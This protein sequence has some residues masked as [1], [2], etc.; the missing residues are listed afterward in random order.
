MARRTKPSSVAWEALDY[1]SLHKLLPKSPEDFVARRAQIL[2][3]HLFP[4]VPLDTEGLPKPGPDFM[5]YADDL[6]GPAEVE[7]VEG[8]RGPAKTEVVESNKAAMMAYEALRQPILEYAYVK[9]LYDRDWEG[10]PIAVKGRRVLAEFV[11]GT[12]WGVR[13]QDDDDEP[14][15]YGPVHWRDEAVPKP[16]VMVVGKFPGLAEVGAKD[17]FIGVTSGEFVK[18]LRTCGLDPARDP[19]HWYFTNLV[20]HMSVDPARESLAG[21][22]VKNCLPLL[23]IELR[24]FRPKYVLCFGSEAAKHVVGPAAT[25]R[26]MFGRVAERVIAVNRTSEPRKTFSFSSMVSVHPAYVARKPEAASD[27]A[28]AVGGFWALASGQRTA[29]SET[30]IQHCC[31]YT[32]THLKQVV[33]QIIAEAKPGVAQPIAIDCE[34]H[35]DRPQEPG[36]YLRTIQF[37][38]KSKHAWCVVLNSQGGVP[39][40]K[41]LVGVR[42]ELSR[43][44]K[45]TPGKGQR[46]VR[47]GGHFLRADLPWL[48]AMGLDLRNEYRVAKT[49]EGTRTRGGFDTGY[50]VH[51]FQE[52]IEG[53][54]KLENLASRFCGVPRYDVELQAWKDDYCKQRQLKDAE[55]EGYGQAPD[56]I[57]HRYAL[58]DVDVTFRLFEHFNGTA[59]KQGLLDKPMIRLDD[60]P[61]PTSRE[62]FYASH[63]AALGALEM[64]LAGV[65][66]D[67]VRGNALTQTFIKALEERTTDFRKLI[68]WDLFNP[69]S[70][71]QCRELLFGVALNGKIDKVT[72]EPKRLRPRALRDAKGN[73]T[74][75][76]AMSLGLTPIKASKK[77][78]WERVLREGKQDAFNASTDKETLGILSHTPG[79][80]GEIA[81]KLR[82][83]RFTSQVLKGVLRR[84]FAMSGKLVLDEN[85]DPTYDGGLMYWMGSDGRVRT[86]FFPVETGRWSSSRPN[87][88][89]CSKRR[90]DDY[91]RILGDPDSSGKYHHK[92]GKNLYLHPIRSMLRARPGHVLV[93][94]DFKM[95]EMAMIG[96]LAQ[97]KTM[98]EM[99]VRNTLPESDPNFIDLHS[100]TAINAFKLDSP[101]NRAQLESYNKAKGTNI[102]WG[103]TKDVLK[104]I[105]CSSLRVAAKNVNFGVPY[106]RSAEAIARQCREEGAD[107]SV[108]DAQKLID[109]YHTTYPQISAFLKACMNRVEG[110]GWMCGTF[111][112]LRR[113]PPADDQTVLAE[114]Q[115]QAANFAI[116]NGVADAMNRACQNVYDYRAKHQA[117]GGTETFEMCLQIHD[118]LLLE[119]PI[120]SVSWVVDEVLPTCMR[121]L[122]EIWPRDLDGVPLPDV[123]SAYRLDVDLEVFQHWGEKI[124]PTWAKEVGLPPKTEKGHKLYKDAA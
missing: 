72:G 13:T 4:L 107:V 58:Y 60:E 94:A 18:A 89:N 98:I 30:D 5:R 11:S 40:F 23:E 6:L 69:N 99:V 123:E 84:P 16:R 2:D 17:N 34:W 48:L 105:G 102:I 55:L 39:A 93:E 68:R 75:H 62:G 24:V 124:D 64:E 66:I 54:Y 74:R 80:K 101:A 44:F 97:D 116:Q 31:I 121:D 36:A 85:D 104:A 49:A 12:T 108:E 113:F 9:A 28:N 33:D 87:L 65:E 96:W 117:K 77:M 26:K 56:E 78:T 42:A 82:D 19:T 76:G 35:G 120:A 20:K 22:W 71:E 70:V 122:V 10:L 47:I 118:A 86:H 41:G 95:A 81:G 32:L 115:R 50:M 37:T 8:L 92:D 21:D 119:V 25:V 7:S 79:E 109:A 57:L 112:R 45:S 27:L 15:F 110:P 38:H 61:G 91:L 83:L 43:L 114:Q 73:V 90:E 67:T 88:Q 29:D 53:G 46:K 1:E 111:G 103:A 51:A 63:V 106:G 100:L 3:R 59:E 14:G 52:S